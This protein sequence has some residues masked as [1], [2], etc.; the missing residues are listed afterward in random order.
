MV[1]LNSEVNRIKN[2]LG[3]IGCR[4]MYGKNCEE[5]VKEIIKKV[6][7]SKDTRAWRNGRRSGLKILWPSGRAGSSPA[8]RTNRSFKDFASCELPPFFE[9]GA[10]D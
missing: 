4:T 1:T 2:E 7:E 9:Y 6:V 8:A 3:N 10:N 5:V